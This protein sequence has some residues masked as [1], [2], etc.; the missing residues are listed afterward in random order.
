MRPGQRLVLLGQLGAAV[1]VERRRLVVFDVRRALAA[2][3]DVVARKRDE[4]GVRAVQRG[5]EVAR[6]ERVH[7][8]GRLL[9]ALGAV[10]VGVGG[11]VQHDVGREGAH[12]GRD[13]A[14]VAQVE[15]LLAGDEDL[16]REQRL[17]GA[18]ELAA[19]AG[20]QPASLGSRRVRRGG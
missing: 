10:D 11:R 4:L 9:V 3:E 12:G 13:G 17:E 8:V 20:E 6:A 19:A 14:R 16:A 2:V 18:R 15:R 7:G 5:D 1:G